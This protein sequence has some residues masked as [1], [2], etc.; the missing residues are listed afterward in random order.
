MRGS[1]PQIETIGAPQS[2]TALRHSSTVSISLIV[3][4]YSRMRPQPVHVRL[5]VC[6]GSSIITRGNFFSPL[7]LFLVRY[8][9]ILAVKLSGTLIHYPHVH[10]DS[11]FPLRELEPR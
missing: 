1:P 10:F 2:S 3:D 9:A 4:L 8:P 7:R 11:V 6:R 5:Q